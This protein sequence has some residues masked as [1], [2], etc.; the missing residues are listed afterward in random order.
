MT[1]EQKLEGAARQLGGSKHEPALQSLA[2]AAR[3]ELTA[4]PRARAW[5]LDGA[6]VLAL[7]LVMGLTAAALMSW[8][9]EQ[10][11]SSLAKYASASA[12]FVFMGVAS[13][14]WLRP[15]GA[16]ARGVM[17]GAFVAVSAVALSGLSGFDPGGPFWKGMSCALVECAVALVPV[18]VVVALSVRFA[19]QPTHVA[20]GA[21]SAAAGGTLALHFHCP[22]GTLAHVALFHLAPALVLAGLAVLVRR[23]LRPRSFVP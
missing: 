4:H 7:N 19:A 18:V 2:A 15:G 12:W 22:N 5:W 13:M 9:D 10:H 6:V 14:A 20:L 1:P 23:G 17:L 8:N 21:L 11:A 16:R 3:A